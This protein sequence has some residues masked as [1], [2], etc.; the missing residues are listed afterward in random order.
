MTVQNMMEAIL[1]NSPNC[2]ERQLIKMKFR[3]KSDIFNHRKDWHKIKNGAVFDAIYSYDV[4]NWNLGKC[5]IKIENCR[6]GDL[7]LEDNYS[8]FDGKIISCE[9]EQQTNE[10]F[11]FKPSDLIKFIK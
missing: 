10:Y 6:F 1:L 7:S 3:E 2:L 9:M 5:R 11:S 8:Q 4:N